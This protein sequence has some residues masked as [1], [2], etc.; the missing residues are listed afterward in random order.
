MQCILTF[1]FFLFLF[2]RKRANLKFREQDGKNKNSCDFVVN[3][4][5]IKLQINNVKTPESYEEKEEELKLQGNHIPEVRIFERNRFVLE[6][7][8]F[9]ISCCLS[10]VPCHHGLNSGSF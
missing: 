10:V 2:Q 6:M 8:A 4:S 5:Q 7:L 9:F 3:T 1:S